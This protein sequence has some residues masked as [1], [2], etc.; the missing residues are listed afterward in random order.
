MGRNARLKQ[1]RKLGTSRDFILSSSIHEELENIATLLKT[2]ELSLQFVTIS[3]TPT[4]VEVTQIYRWA[5]SHGL[6]GVV[7]GGAP[8]S[9]TE[10]MIAIGKE[11]KVM[12]D[13]AKEFLK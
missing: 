6:I 7:F 2:T 9:N 3:R 12:I 1:Q 10:A 11:K 4:E 13:L 5:N 8:G